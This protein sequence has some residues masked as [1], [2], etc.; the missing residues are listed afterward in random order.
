[1]PEASYSSPSPSPSPSPLMPLLRWIGAGVTGR[2]GRSSSVGKSVRMML[3][4][5]PEGGPE[6]VVVDELVRS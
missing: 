2:L 5:W 4:R 6:M 3:G 1:V